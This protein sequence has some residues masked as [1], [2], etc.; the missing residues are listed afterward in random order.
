[1]ETRQSQTHASSVAS[2]RVGGLL[3]GGTK[4]NELL[5]TVTGAVLIVL[6]AV[7]GITLLRIH[8]LLSVHMFLGMLLIGPL[9]LKLGSTGYRFVRYYTGNPR[10]ASKGA[11]PTPLRLIAPIVVLSTVVVVGSGVVLLFAGPGARA[12]LLP[13]HKYSFFIWAA[14]TAL[15]VLGHLP[16]LR[17][18]LS[19]DYGP[20]AL[21]G[22]V[23]AGRAGRVVS[24]ASAVTLGAV[25]AVLCIPQ[26]GPWLHAVFHH[27]H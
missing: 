4:G 10:Y 2:A 6:L 19:E 5:T 15:H 22:E 17:D 9:T 21:R 26:F 25:I 14:F 27:H 11:P 23:T 24:L 16:A 18:S 3:A 20:P 13:I 8:A 1:M 12:T 7:I